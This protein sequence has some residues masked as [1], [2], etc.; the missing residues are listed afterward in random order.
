MTTDDVLDQADAL[1]QRHRSFVARRPEDIEAPPVAEGIEEEIPILTDIVDEED[2]VTGLPEDLKA[3]IEE[4]LS[5]WLVEA[6]PAA[7]ANASQHIISELDAKARHTLLPRLQTLA[8]S[9]PIKQEEAQ[10]R[11]DP[12][13]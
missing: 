2:L 8:D 13:L 11:E 10:E 4:E 7:V 6:L 5:A 12:P 3:A 9:R 1:M